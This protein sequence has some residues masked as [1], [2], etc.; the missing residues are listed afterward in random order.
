MYRHLSHF[1]LLLLIIPKLC[2][3]DN[4]FPDIEYTVHIDRTLYSEPGYD[5]STYV[6]KKRNGHKNLPS[7]KWATPGMHLQ[8]I[9]SK[10]TEDG[11][12]YA[13]VQDTDNPKNKGWLKYNHL[14]YYENGIRV[15]CDPNTKNQ[16][17]TIA[18][19]IAHIEKNEYKSPPLTNSFS[20]L[21]ADCSDYIDDNGNY[22]DR[23]KLL[24]K[25]ILGEGRST[26]RWEYFKQ[27]SRNL[28]S[29]CPNFNNLNDE[30]KL[31]FWI[32]TFAAIAWDEGKCISNIARS[33]ATNGLAVSDFQLPENWKS[34][35][36]W[37]GPG[38]NA[39]GRAPAVNIR[40]RRYGNFLMANPSNSIPC[41]VEI[42]SGSLCGFYSYKKWPLTCDPV[43]KTK[44]FTG[45]H[46]YWE[47]M[48]HNDA[49]FVKM[50]KEFPLCK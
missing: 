44:G 36:S 22:G 30:E 35:R 13:H 19:I 8:L 5:Y 7:R 18:E 6:T 27:G 43:E 29:V 40:R 48:K 34:G 39:N 33:D 50:I 31:N 11:Q 37:R 23:G 1:L 45:K 17:K 26:D 49:K 41:A 42:M 10:V 12:M 38:C 3:A 46:I 47:K 21:G 15:Q 16:T 28:S 20:A 4:E 2:F 9:E 14:Y 24:A 25:E 32:W